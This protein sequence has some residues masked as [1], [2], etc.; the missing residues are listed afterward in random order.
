[1]T[2]I[3]VTEL[4]YR[5]ARGVFEAAA[6]DGFS[7]VPMPA[8]E[9]DLAAAVKAAGARHVI[10]G[11]EKYVGPLYDALPAGAVIARFG[12]GHDGVDKSLAALRGQRCTN[13]PGVLDDSVA[14]HT[15]NLMLA[16]GR[17]TVELAARTKSG[18]WAPCVGTELRGKTLAVIGCGPIGRRVAQIA[19]AGFKAWVIGSDV[20]AMDVEEAKREWGFVDVVR[21]FAEAV[22]EAD[23][24]SLHIPSTPKT[25]HFMNAQRLSAMPEHAWLINTARGAIVDEAALYDAV[26]QARIGGAALDVFESEP[27]VPVDPEKDLRT[28]DRV[29]MT[30]HVSSSTQEACHRMADRALANIFLAEAGRVAEMDLL[31]RHLMEAH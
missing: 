3:G 21:D 24:V 18:E 12:V 4:E 11:V 13:T 14:E 26:S 25:R 19:S 29:I 7:C 31:N 22:S 17:R 6:K 2:V 16:A 23:F 9:A 5:K 30:P 15:I 28:L 10:I 27:Y 1:M 8:A 20:L